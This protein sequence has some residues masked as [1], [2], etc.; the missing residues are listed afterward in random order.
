MAGGF[1]GAGVYRVDAAGQSFVLKVSGERESPATWRRTH[2]I[3]QL[4]ADAGLAPRIVHA[5]ES[6]RA[7]V[8]AFVAGRSF[9]LLY[10]DPR[11]RDAALARLA[12]TLR[13]VH[14]L[15]T[16]H[17][18]I[19]TDPR[20]LLVARW[21][22]LEMS[23]TLPAFVGHA[24]RRVLTINAPGPARVPVLSHND[25]NPTNLV[26]D[27]ENVLLLDWEAAGPNDPYY[28]LATIALFLR[29]NNDSCQR[30]LAAY[31]AAP[32]AAI[33]A[34]FVYIRRLVAVLAGVTF[35]QLAGER[36]PS[37][38]ASDETLDSIPS[39]G[40]CYQRMRA[41]TLNVATKEG[42]LSFGLALVKESVSPSGG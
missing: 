37:E 3:Q 36:G 38:T 18:A 34:R 8:S 10:G 32:V 26:Y 30:L 24:A 22:G 7:V 28:D 39:L 11:T 20:E 33:P 19:A 4:A 27:G 16:P 31:D 14:G 9:P 13:G 2:D 17:D 5:D 35:L 1:S 25:V 15:P 12:R 42:K 23:S 6:R 21:S 40:D 29:M 41:G